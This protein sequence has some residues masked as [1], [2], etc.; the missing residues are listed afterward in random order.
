MP[1]DKGAEPNLMQPIGLR[2]EP[3]DPRTKVRQISRDPSGRMDVLGHLVPGHR[4][5]ASA[6]GYTLPAR[7]VGFARC[8]TNADRTP[9]RISIPA[10]GRPSAAKLFTTEDIRP[11]YSR[12][13]DSYRQE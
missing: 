9:R 6:L 5:A 4:P 12:S 8:Y 1:W 3:R 7:W 2:E 10:S 11:G 13:W